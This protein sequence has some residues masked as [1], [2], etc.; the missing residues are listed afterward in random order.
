MARQKAPALVAPALVALALAVAG[1]GSGGVSA[2]AAVT[3][4]AAAPLC[5]EA[6]GELRSGGEAVD[7][8]EVRVL[9][10]APV[11]PGAGSGGADLAA[12]GADA[13]R[14]T[15]D[16]TAVAY[17]E[18]PGPAA[19]FTHSIVAAADIAWVQASSAAKV[20]RRIDRALEEAGSSSPRAAVLDKV[21]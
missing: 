10:L 17:L 13:R 1:C 16:S 12:A 20:M 5:E 3:I 19:R 15:E 18:S 4:Y 11:A 14:A 8:L 7:G 2:G 9:C 21:G 6:R